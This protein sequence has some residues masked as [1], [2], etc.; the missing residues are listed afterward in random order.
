MRDGDWRLLDC[1]PVWEGNGTCDG[2]IAFEWQ[3]DTARVLVVVNYASNQG[4]CHVRAPFS[5][6][7]GRAVRLIDLANGASYDRA[8]ND[9][10]ATGLY[11]DLPPWGYHVFEVTSV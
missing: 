8:G 4:Q 6:L 5:D 11:V 9:L 7:L 2:F 10:A 3:R 1:T